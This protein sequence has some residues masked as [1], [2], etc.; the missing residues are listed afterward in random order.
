MVGA[1]PKA[2]R[3][4]GSD[5]KIMMP[6]YP[7]VKALL[8]SGKSVWRSDD[9]FGGKA[10]LKSV[11]AEGLDLLLLD[12]QHLYDR[13][14]S[15]YLDEAGQDWH[16]NH[17][18]FGALCRVGAEVCLNGIG[19][20][21]PDIAHAHDWQAGLIPVYLK[22]AGASSPKSVITIHNIAFQ[23]LFDSSTLK[24]LGID[25]DMFTHE[26]VEYWG[27]VGF[28]KSGIALADKVTTVS[29]TYAE[30][31]MEPEFGMGLEGLMQHRR[32]DLSGILNG[33]DLDVWNPATD[34][35]LKR[36]YTARSLKRKAENRAEIEK[37][38][39]LTA[40]A[41]GP[42]FCVVSR[43][44]TQKGLDLLLD[45]LPDLVGQGA[46][47]AL[48]GSGDPQI[49]DGFRRASKQ[50]AG[51]VGAIIGYDEDLSHLLQ[52]GADA[53]LVPSRFEPCGLT[54]LYG[55]R[56]GTLPVVAK[57]GGLA[58]TV[59]DATAENVKSKKATGFSFSPVSK[60]GLVQVI[61]RT[62]EM[63]RQPELWT[64]MQRSAM[65]YPV[66]WGHS[67]ELYQKLYQQMMVDQSTDDGNLK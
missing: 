63:Y 1:V 24:I 19:D 49:E 52:G 30:E 27:K 34:K 18:R 33:I 14:G 53:I 31:L 40:N 12:A 15:I 5:V 6:A 22:Q 57:T 67:A 3:E 37:R 9:L 62:C 48:L 43:L 65:R 56:Y 2:L 47:L 23:G 61:A 16:D 64:S 25:D 50:Y 41:T 13:P 11:Q 51:S 4:L 21:K 46:Q 38:F 10:Q 66:D 17:L 32:V 45:A 36:N 60:E 28:L 59:I 8:K 20:W 35:A 29:P 58:D 54:Q 39:G 44:T 42:L 7:S 55:L 26:R